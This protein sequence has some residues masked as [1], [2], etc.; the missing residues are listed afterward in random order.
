MI[1]AMKAQTE[2][3]QLATKDKLIAPVPKAKHL[4]K[5]SPGMTRKGFGQLVKRAF[6]SR[7]PKPAPKLP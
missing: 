3:E 2:A 5:K 4:P 7:A 1:K 6:T